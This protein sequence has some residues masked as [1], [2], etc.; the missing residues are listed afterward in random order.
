LRAVVYERW[1]GPLTL[2]ERPAPV[3]GRGQLRV[4]V[5]AA[6]LNPKDVLVHSGR[7][8]FLTGRGFP[9]TPGY[10]FAGEVEAVGPGADDLPIGAPVWGFT[11]GWRGGAL[12]ESVVV[13]RDEAGLRPTSLTAEEACGIP[14]AAA[15][16]LQGLRDQARLQPGERVLVHG[17]SGGVG[18]LALQIVRALGGVP[19]A[20]CSSANEGLVRSLGA[21]DVLPYDTGAFAASRERWDVV[22]D[23]FGTLP[24]AK[25][26][27]RLRPGGRH[28]ALVIRGSALVPGIAGR[29][30]LL[31]AHMVV[32]RARRGD[33]DVLARWV[34]DGRLR[35]VI[36]QVLP[37]ERAADGFA[38]IRSK[39]AR[40]KVV[41][42][43]GP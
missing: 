23:A 29:L 28:L 18:T 26:R 35:P 8:W 17:A 32:V 7:F 41:I 9:R 34:E 40:G 39:R 6:A 31:G 30:G 42:R 12:A 33:F 27:D 5:Q 36:D 3:P 1:R 4:R 16:V 15:T 38:R 11:D 21:Q 20:V 13:Y 19:T 25:S 24:W 43:V 2:T 37:L 22:L 14:L 10:D